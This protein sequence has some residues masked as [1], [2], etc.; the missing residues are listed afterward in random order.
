MVMRSAIAAIFLAIMFTNATAEHQEAVVIG[1]GASTCAEFAQA[2]KRDPAAAM[3]VYFSWTQGFMSASNFLKRAIKQKERDLNGLSGSEQE[4][5]L[6]NFCDR[7]PL[8]NFGDA[9]SDLYYSLPELS[10]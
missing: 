7:R 1:V 10:P 3:A 9:I 6:R 2:Y 4:D 5:R 8:A